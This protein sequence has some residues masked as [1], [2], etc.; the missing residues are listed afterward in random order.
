[1]VAIPAR[2]IDEAIEAAE[3]IARAEESIRRAIEGGQDLRSARVA[4]GYFI[5]NGATN[6]IQ[7]ETN[8]PRTM[9]F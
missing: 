9:W 1:V 8:F 6:F 2:A 4:V 7:P 3:E 5:S